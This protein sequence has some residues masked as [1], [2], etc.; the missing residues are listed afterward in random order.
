MSIL[1]EC[2]WF[3]IVIGIIILGA[4]IFRLSLTLILG[5]PGYY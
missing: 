2:I 1:E 4:F 3:W 5:P